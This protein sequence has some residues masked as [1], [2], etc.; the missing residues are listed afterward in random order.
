MH[1]NN[2]NEIRRKDK[3]LSAER[4]KDRGAAFSSLQINDKDDMQK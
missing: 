2:K 1:P 3:Y 4:R